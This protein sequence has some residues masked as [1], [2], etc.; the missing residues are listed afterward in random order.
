MIRKLLPQHD[1]Q[2]PINREFFH[3][4]VQG[5]VVITTNFSGTL[6]VQKHKAIREHIL[7]NMDQWTSKN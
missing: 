5:E 7:E 1:L 6:K 3:V 2:S 4:S